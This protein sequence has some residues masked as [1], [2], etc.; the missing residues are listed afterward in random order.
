MIKPVDPLVRHGLHTLDGPDIVR[1]AVVVPRVD[2][3]ECDGVAVRDELFEARRDQPVVAAVDEVLVV[4]ARAVV[5]LRYV[6]LAGRRR[7]EQRGT[8]G[9]EP[10]RRGRHV[11]ASTETVDVGLVRIPR[12][13]V[14]PHRP[15]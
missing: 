9:E 13:V 1:L 5:L 11:R 8:Y 6:K 4:C 14:I 2:L 15:A 12:H 10:R 7:R 3:D